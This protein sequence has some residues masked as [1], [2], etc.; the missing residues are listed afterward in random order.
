[1][2]T[3]TGDEPGPVPPPGD[4]LLPLGRE[5]P[6]R[7]SEWRPES[8]FEPAADE[9]ARPSSDF[10][11]FASG[12]VAEPDA[13]GDDVGAAP[14]APE[15]SAVERPT[16][17]PPAPP[18]RYYPA[19]PQ[20]PAEPYPTRFEILYPDRLSRWKTFFRLPLLIPAMLFSYLVQ[21]FLFAGLVVGW[22]TVF[23]RKKYPMWLFSGLSGAFGF[24]ARLSAYQ[25]LLT[26][27][28][29]SF[30][31][32]ASMV[33]LE[34]DDPPQGHLSRWRVFWWK[35]ALLIPHFVVLY[36][37]QLALN[38]VTILAWFGIMF[39]GNYPRGMFAFAV[40]V[41]RWQ[42]R[43]K[44][45]FAS[46]NDRYPPYALS[47]HAGPAGNGAVVG[48]GIAG[49]LLFGGIAVL[50]TIGIIV[51]AMQSPHTEDVNYA[52]LQ[53]GRGNVTVVYNNLSSDSARL[54]LTITRVT[55]PGDELAPVL[56]PGASE[57]L[58]VFEWTVTNPEGA[59]SRSVGSDAAHLKYADHGDTTTRSAE[60][61]TVGSRTAPETIGEGGTTRVR[62]VFVVPD[63]AQP[64]ELRFG[65]SAGAAVRYRFH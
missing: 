58:I 24:T 49:G 43:I 23:W 22:T 33:S 65:F 7:G 61:I 3:P 54:R 11:S 64:V 31:V 56:P 44:S 25:Y 30:S 45:Y 37:L 55:D 46:F 15:A 36:F 50:M 4:P 13:A 59:S 42:W 29:P 52:Q 62:A 26:D 40:G 51:I 39:T 41:Q 47:E 53:Q 38:V 8:A 63:T 18:L 28:F 5:K 48:S 27:K 12:E 10:P 14:N 1:M 60:F 2:T 35:L 9:A 34:F 19:P 20:A 6:L 32:D 57:R 21:G 17:P 16:P